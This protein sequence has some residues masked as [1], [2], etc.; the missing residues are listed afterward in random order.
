[1]EIQDNIGMCYHFN[2]FDN[3]IKVHSNYLCED[4]FF[5]N[6]DFYKEYEN[7]IVYTFYPKEYN[8]IPILIDNPLSLCKVEKIK[9]K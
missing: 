5:E 2:V 9:N 7:I 8:W 4:Y 6:Q 3:R 1:M